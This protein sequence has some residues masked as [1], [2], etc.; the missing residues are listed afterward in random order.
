MCGY[1]RH[2]TAKILKI[3]QKSSSQEFDSYHNTLSEM[4]MRGGILNYY[5]I[6]LLRYTETKG[7]KHYSCILPSKTFIQRHAWKVESV[8][9]MLCPVEEHEDGNPIREGFSFCCK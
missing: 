8:G 6:E 7:V 3:S 5:G 9:S 2:I 4:E 1:W